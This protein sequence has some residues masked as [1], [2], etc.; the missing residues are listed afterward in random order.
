MEKMFPA[1]SSPAANEQ[2]HSSALTLARSRDVS[3][4]IPGTAGCQGCHRFP[5][6]PPTRQHLVSNTAPASDSLPHVH[7]VF[8]GHAGPASK[9]GEGRR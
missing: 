4:H 1:G 8:Q 2:S 6:P 5:V 7:E 3:W 9:W